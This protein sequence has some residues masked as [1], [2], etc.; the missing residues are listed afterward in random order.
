MRIIAT[1]PEE[2]ELLAELTEH[3]RAKGIYPDITRYEDGF[4]VTVWSIGDLDEIPTAKDWPL[5][6]R[7]RF[8]ELYG[9]K[10]GGATDDAWSRMRSYVDEYLE[11]QCSEKPSMIDVSIAKDKLQSFLDSGL[12][13]AYSEESAISI[14]THLRSHGCCCEVEHRSTPLGGFWL[15]KKAE[16]D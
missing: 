11:S 1:A 10:I 14:A 4:G 15:I 3:I 5:E 2:N 8:M 6:E 7:L 12:C 9:G 13:E 16:A